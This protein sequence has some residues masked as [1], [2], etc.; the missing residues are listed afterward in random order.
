LASV[1]VTYI[2]GAAMATVV[3]EC[4]EAAQVELRSA[5]LETN[6]RALERPG[7]VKR[8]GMAF[9]APLSAIR[10][11]SVWAEKKVEEVLHCE[12]GIQG[13]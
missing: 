7:P 9:S 6:W 4:D 13:C 10:V 5:K 11:L 1:E 3:L 12:L 8:V 2:F